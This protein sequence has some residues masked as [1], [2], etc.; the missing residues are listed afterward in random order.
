MPVTAM[1]AGLA[2]QLRGAGLTY[3]EVGQAAGMLPPGYHYQRRSVLAGSCPRAF[4][5]AADALFSWRV[6]LRAGLRVSSSSA[7]VGQDAAVMLSL[8]PPPLRIAAPCRLVYVVD[9]P[10]RR[11]LAFGTLPGHPESGEEAFLIQRRD[12]GEVIFTITAFSR[13]AVLLAK[14]AG[15]AG[16]AIQRHITTRYLRALAN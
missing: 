8:G 12:N 6:H 13:P 2:S 5:A 4:T 3:S 15:P 1:A 9:E 14:A 11:G 10:D 16:R 7:L